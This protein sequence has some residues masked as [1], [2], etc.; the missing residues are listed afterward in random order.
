MPLKALQS[1]H[2]LNLG[3]KTNA[4]VA[5]SLLDHPAMG[6]VVGFTNSELKVFLDY[7]GQSSLTK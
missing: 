7:R 5:K 1:P 4:R 2:A 3:S 6:R